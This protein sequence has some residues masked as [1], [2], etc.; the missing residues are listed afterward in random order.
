MS[1]FE[2]QVKERFLRYVKIDTQSKA[3][4]KRTPSTAKQLDLAKLLY[5]ELAQMKAKWLHLDEKHCLVYAKIPGNL[6]QDMPFGLI[7]HLDT[8]PDASGT[9]VKPWIYEKYDGNA[10]ILNEK[11]GIKMSPASFPILKQY[12]GQDLVFTDGTTLLGGDD[13]ASIAAIMTFAEYLLAHPKAPHPTICLAF[14][15]DEEVGGLAKDLD[16]KR[17]GAPYAYT[18]DG[19]HLGYYSYETFNASEAQIEIN[20]LLV[21]TGT[22]KGLMK[23]A[24]AIG[25][26]IIAG[27]PAKERPE[28]TSKRQGFFHPFVFEGD[29]SHAYLR[30]LIRD[31]EEKGFARRENLI[32][33]LVRKA[34]DEY[35][36]G[37]VTLNFANGYRSMKNAVM[38]YPF[39]IEG[40]VAAIARAGVKPVELPFRGGTDGSA[41]SNRGLPCPNLSAGYENA[42]GPYEFVSIQSMAKNVEILLALAKEFAK[43]A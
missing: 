5:E 43:M 26:Q 19:D 10:V 42:H 29:V 3:N 4:V 14:T 37:T 35:G 15:P 34:N 32:K 18:L 7:A 11:L 28:Y 20:G 38:G 16:L 17:F 8:A 33:E 25:N 39:L 13:K 30:I 9:D 6:K 12:I 22:A 31:F 41:L 36:K 23:N 1:Q 27:L 40:L 24:V 2:H 21:H